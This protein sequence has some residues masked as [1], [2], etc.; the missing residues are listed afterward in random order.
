MADG[1]DGRFAQRIV[2]IGDE[3]DCVLVDVR[4]QIEGGRGDTRF[5]VAHGSRRVAVHRAEVALTV[6]QHGAHGEILRQARHRFVDRR[7]AVGVVLAQHFAD[8]TGG[9]LVGAVGADAH[10]I[11]GIQNAPLD[12]F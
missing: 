5:G 9:F 12:G 2:E 6:H 1:Q 3:I 8:D 4:Q 7:V 10:V 11:H